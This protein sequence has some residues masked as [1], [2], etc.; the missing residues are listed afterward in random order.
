MTLL[1]ARSAYCSSARWRRTAACSPAIPSSRRRR[2]PI[3]RLRPQ[4]SGRQQ[5]A[6][7]QAARGGVRVPRIIVVARRGGGH[8]EDV[9]SLRRGS[10]CRGLHGNRSPHRSPFG[11]HLPW[12]WKAHRCLQLRH[13]LGRR[14]PDRQRGAVKHGLQCLNP[15]GQRGAG[16]GKVGA[17]GQRRPGPERGQGG[18]P[19]L[20]ANAKR[21]ARALTVQSRRRSSDRWHQGPDPC[22]A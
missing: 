14:R 21:G 1:P 12:V 19:R 13:R 8:R 11:R 10:E 17:R 7:V 22:R 6:Q 4:V 18:I 9:D 2:S 15:R 5:Q 20:P 16:G 3:A